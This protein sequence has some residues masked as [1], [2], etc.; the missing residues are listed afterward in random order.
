M[1]L[2]ILVVD[3]EPAICDLVCTALEMAG[4]TTSRSA[5][6]NFAYQS[7]INKRPDLIICDWMMPMLNGIDL[8]KQLRENERTADLPV[9]MLTAKGDEDD[10]LRGFNVGVDDYLAKPFSTRELVARV[11]AILRRA[12]PTP[13]T[14]TSFAGIDMDSDQQSCKAAGVELK[15]GPLEYRLL[16]LFVRHPNRVFS[17]DQILDRVWGGN[18][19]VDE[20]TVDVHI[21]RVRKALIPVNLEGCIQTIRGR[22]YRISELP[23]IE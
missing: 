21:R 17:R 11:K 10:R 19:Y 7:V 8:V 5:N 16:E 23:E 3:D 1:P 4:Y 2:H 20:R 13:E 22:G 18:V 15:L 12:T 9:L 14:I 6:G